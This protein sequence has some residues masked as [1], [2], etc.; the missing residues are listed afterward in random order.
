MVQ[1]LW[2][3][4]KQLFGN[5]KSKNNIMQ[6]NGK[7]SGCDIANEINHFFADI[8]PGLA[9]KIPDSI[10]TLLNVGNVRE[11]SRFYIA[12]SAQCRTTSC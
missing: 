3:L 8:S 11:I 12:I 1:K 10:L 9:S 6:I 4:V 2:R 7:T 5:P